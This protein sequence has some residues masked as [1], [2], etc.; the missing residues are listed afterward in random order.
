MTGDA[1]EWDPGQPLKR[2]KGESARAN[3]ALVDYALMG[4]GRSLRRLHTR[5]SKQTANKEQ[6]EK[7]PTT[8]WSTLA[9]WSFRYRWQERVARFDEL[10]A[11]RW[12]KEWRDRRRGLLAHLGERV[13]DA[14]NA[15]VVDKVTLDQVVRVVQVTVQEMREEYHEKAPQRYELDV[16]S[17]GKGLDQVVGEAFERALDRIYGGSSGSTGGDDPTGEVPAD[18]AGGGVPA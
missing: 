6:T 13:E 11:D 14:L 1:F 4:P 3:A 8:Q 15:L 9:G 18:G 17:D 10:E 5:Y 7:P 2:G 12:A 16:T